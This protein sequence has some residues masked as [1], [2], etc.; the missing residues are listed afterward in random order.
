MV[1][2]LDSIESHIFESIL[3]LI[4][5]G[6]VEV[7]DKDRE[8]FQKAIVKLELIDI[9]G[10]P[11]NELI[12]SVNFELNDFTAN[13]KAK[14]FKLDDNSIKTSMTTTTNS[15]DNNDPVAGNSNPLII[16][17]INVYHQN[18]S[19][20]GLIDRSIKEQCNCWW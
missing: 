3:K 14:R 13:N 2:L 5:T 4:Y 7:F 8:A 19:H 11:Q 15:P 6:V 9:I 10:E 12:G 17:I 1:V 16:T 20:R 18:R